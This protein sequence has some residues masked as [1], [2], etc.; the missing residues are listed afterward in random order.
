MNLRLTLK[1]QL[2]SSVLIIISLK[3]LSAVRRIRG[4]EGKGCVGPSVMMQ[5]AR[6]RND[7]CVKAWM[8]FYEKKAVQKLL[9]TSICGGNRG[10]GGVSSHR[11]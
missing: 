7:V 9:T 6:L 2:L 1:E 8:Y 5:S 11:R 10:P 3:T 4:M